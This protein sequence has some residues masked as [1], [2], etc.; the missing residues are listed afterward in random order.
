MEGFG[1][2][3]VDTTED[4]TRH[5]AITLRIGLE[6][7]LA[8][9]VLTHEYAHLLAWDY[10]GRNHD[11]IWGIAYAEVYAYVFGDH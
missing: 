8:A 10:H 3:V 9:E 6:P 4:G 2:S 1:E 5:A 7:D 11:A